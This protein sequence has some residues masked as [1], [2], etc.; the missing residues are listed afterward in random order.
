MDHRRIN[1]DP[2]TASQIL[3]YEDTLVER[4]KLLLSP[5]VGYPTLPFP[6]TQLRVAAS[7]RLCFNITISMLLLSRL[8]LLLLS[9][10]SFVAAGILH[11]HGRVHATQALPLS[12]RAVF[13]GFQIFETDSLKGLGLGDTCEKVLYQSLKCDDYVARFST[14]A[15]RRS[16]K[17]QT[18]TTSV[19]E[20]SCQGAL[21]TFSR[22]ANAA[23]AGKELYSGYPAAALIDTVWGG[24]NETCVFE[25]APSDKNCNGKN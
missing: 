13:Q 8:L 1:P 21:T 6:Q 14:V 19:C 23:C 5:W 22:R 12:S 18:L 2:D 20:K 16:L 11:R 24:W 3:P 25:V 7:D 4:R 9:A 15:Y 10:T 17:D